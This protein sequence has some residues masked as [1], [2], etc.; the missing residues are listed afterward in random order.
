MPVAEGLE[1]GQRISVFG[2]S[3]AVKVYVGLNS[4]RIFV[5]VAL[6]VAALAW[7]FVAS[8]Q[9]FSFSDLANLPLSAIAIAVAAL[10]ASNL[11]AIARIKCVARALGYRVLWGHSAAAL[12]VGALGAAVFFQIAGQLIGRNWILGRLNI[13]PGTVVIITGIERALALIVSFTLAL[14]G[15]GVI[16]GRAVTIDPNAGGS[17][18]MRTSAGLLFVLAVVCLVCWRQTIVDFYRQL[19]AK[20]IVGLVIAMA[21]SIV[22]QLTTMAAY[23]AIALPFIS[24]DS[25]TPLLAA[26]AIIMFL[27]S[28]PISFAGWGVRELSAVAAFGSIGMASHSAF[29]VAATVGIL[30]IVTMLLLAAVSSRFL[31]LPRDAV[32]A[33]G[34]MPLGALALEKTLAPLVAVLVFFSIYVPISSGFANVTLSDPVAIIGG[35]L[36]LL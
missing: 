10:L 8:G 19:T 33:T 32:A 7:L 14:A 3:L 2:S 36:F 12:S 31:S 24:A 27:A 28:V 26:I 23:L 1:S 35:G 34:R 21:L 16:Y 17:V 20:M 13:S 5:S 15:A 18:L 9:E 29:I 11:L 22:I 4:I 25:L 30:S 6:L